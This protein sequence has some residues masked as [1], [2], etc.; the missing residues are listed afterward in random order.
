MIGEY[1]EIDDIPKEFFRCYPIERE[2]SHLPLSKRNEEYSLIKEDYFSEAYWDSLGEYE[3]YTI[4]LSALNGNVN[5][6]Y[7]LYEYLYYLQLKD[8]SCIGKEINIVLSIGWN[9]KEMYNN[10]KVSNDIE[11]YYYKAYTFTLLP[12]IIPILHLQWMERPPYH[13]EEAF[14]RLSIDLVSSS[15]YLEDES[16]LLENLIT[17]KTYTRKIQMKNHVIKSVKVA[18][19]VGT[20]FVSD[21]LTIDVVSAEEVKIK[22]ANLQQVMTVDEATKLIEES[23]VGKK[24]DEFPKHIRRMMEETAIIEDIN[25]T[26]NKEKLNLFA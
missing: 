14:D 17:I 1:E 18:L 11:P 23:M 4:H 19:T 26:I 22:K 3:Y 12:D 10:D 5:G 13:P 7:S 25:F 16:S 2:I 20:G 15:K 6:F 21:E 8:E 24:V 9:E